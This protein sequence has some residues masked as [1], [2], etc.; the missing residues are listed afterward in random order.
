[1]ANYDNIFELNK[2]SFHYPYE[3]PV[4]KDLN[5]EIKRGEKICILG[6][7]GCGKSTLL[8]M[9]CG[10]LYPQEGIFK[11][12]DKDIS[13]KTMLDKQFSKE[14][15]KRIGFIFQNSD[16]QLFSSTVKEEIA[17]GPLQLNMTAEEVK[18][19]VEDV[20]YLLNIQHL[21]DKTPFKLSGGEKKK[22][23]I[24]SVLVM[25]PEV[26]ILDEPTNGLDPK[27]QRWLVELLIQL[28]KAGK[29]IITSTHNLELVQEISDRAIV[30]SEEH[31]IAADDDIGKVLEEIELLKKVNLVDEFYHRHGDSGHTH[32][33]MHNF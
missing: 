28:N 10:L 6:A 20:L 22:V 8:K 27:T 3:A 16:V 29:T 25:N 32:Y 9:L 26:L 2:V 7:N 11:A 18:A 31:T 5:L 30:F 24:A 13:E 12:F 1:M 4:L 21:K 33:H 17:F 23:G 14:Y 19:R 15:H